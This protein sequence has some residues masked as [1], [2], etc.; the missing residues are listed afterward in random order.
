MLSESELTGTGDLRR[1]ADCL[2]CGSGEVAEF[3]SL[4]DFPVYCNVRWPT[5]EQAVAAFRRDMRLGFFRNCTHIFNL[6]FDPTLVTYS[7]DYENSL[8]FSPRLHGHVSA[9]DAKG[10]LANRRLA[11]RGA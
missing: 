11:A 8:R 7:K 6:A 1:A 5:R 4:L 3:I 2:V 9:I 10:G